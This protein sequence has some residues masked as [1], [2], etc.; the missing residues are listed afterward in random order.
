[1]IRSPVAYRMDLSSNSRFLSSNP[2]SDVYGCLQTEPAFWQIRRHC[3][4]P[5]KLFC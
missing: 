2:D 3:D 4:R 5:R 1:M